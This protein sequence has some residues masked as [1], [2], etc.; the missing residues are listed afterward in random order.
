VTVSIAR[1][2]GAPVIDPPGRWRGEVEHVGVTSRSPV[3]VETR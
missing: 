2:F 1:I 3:T